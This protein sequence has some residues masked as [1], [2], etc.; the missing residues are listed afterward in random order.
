MPGRHPPSD[1]PRRVLPERE[2]KPSRACADE[3]E[4]DGGYGLWGH[5]RPTRPERDAPRAAPSEA[6]SAR[7][8]GRDAAAAPRGSGRSGGRSGGRSDT[9]DARGGGGRTAAPAASA[10]AAA[11]S[12]P[13]RPTRAERA[14]TDRFQRLCGIVGKHFPE[15]A[16]LIE[17]PGLYCRVLLA[18]QFRRQGAATARL[19]GLLVDVVA[20]RVRAAARGSTGDPFFSAADAGAARRLS[21]EILAAEAEATGGSVAGVGGSSDGGGSDGEAIPDGDGSLPQGFLR[22]A[23][24]AEAWAEHSDGDACDGGAAGGDAHGAAEAPERSRAFAVGGGWQAYDALGILFAGSSDSDDDASDDDGSGQDD[25]DG[26]YGVNYQQQQHQHHHHHQQLQLQYQQYEPQHPYQQQQQQQQLQ[27]YG[28]NSIY[29][30]NNNSNYDGTATDRTGGR[31]RRVPPTIEARV[32]AAAALGLFYRPL[33][34]WAMGHNVNLLL[35]EVHANT[36]RVL[37]IEDFQRTHALTDYEAVAL[38]MALRHNAS[39]VRL[40]LRALPLT[41]RALVPLLDA[42][43]GHPCLRSLELRRLEGREKAA[44]A[45][46]RLVC[47]NPNIIA[48]DAAH[49]GFE[50][51]DAQG[52]TIDVALQLNLLHA[53]DPFVAREEVFGAAT[54]LSSPAAAE[55]MAAAAAAAVGPLPPVLDGVAMASS[56]AAPGV[57]VA[58]VDTESTAAA[59]LERKRLGLLAEAGRH[60]CARFMAGACT[61]RDECWLFHPPPVAGK[62]PRDA[63]GATIRD[64]PVVA[65]PCATTAATAAAALRAASQRAADVLFTRPRLLFTDGVLV[66]DVAAPKRRRLRGSSESDEEDVEEDEDEGDDFSDHEASASTVEEGSADAEDC[67]EESVGQDSSTASDGPSVLHTVARLLPPLVSLCCA[68]V[69][70]VT[71]VQTRARRLAA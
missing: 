14:Q 57:G 50:L 40:A 56:L 33:R 12:R 11:A 25:W 21:E 26:D 41:D 63:S 1:R 29:S 58:G 54:G 34:P 45:L 67:G 59:A 24:G 8:G 62:P 65:E 61:D 5:R 36:P 35:A 71:V 23:D 19:D 39:I 53:A 2:K 28:F 15:L 69:V 52:E 70:L 46:V 51:S 30:K 16:E 31:S 42:L 10:G 9:R 66:A 20:T 48:I 38:G 43:H 37:V 44:R 60:T 4:D 13:P 7:R 3:D 17:S 68:V 47:A 27:P 18:L 64:A 6:G 32:Q 22:S 55:A 49:S